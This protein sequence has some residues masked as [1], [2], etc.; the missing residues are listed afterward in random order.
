MGIQISG[1]YL[2]NHRFSDVIVLMSE[3]TDTPQ[4]MI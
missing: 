4:Q 2:N 3:S 1:E